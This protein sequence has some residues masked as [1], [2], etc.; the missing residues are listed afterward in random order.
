MPVYINMIEDAQRK[1]LSTELSISSATILATATKAVFASHEYPDEFC[2]WE[3]DPKDT[4]TWAAWKLRYKRACEM[5]Q[6]TQQ[7]S[8]GARQSGSANAANG[9]R[10]YAMR[11]YKP[12][13]GEPI[14][15]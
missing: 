7:A 12:S 6:L 11:H 9:T 15:Y 2:K 10:P 3:S 5:R 4:K 8:D 1:L 14:E 13:S